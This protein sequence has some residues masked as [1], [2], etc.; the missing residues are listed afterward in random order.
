MA[1]SPSFLL[2]LVGPGTVVDEDFPAEDQGHGGADVRRGDE[3]DARF[4]DAESE[5][6]SGRDGFGGTVD[7]QQLGFDRADVGKIGRR[8]CRDRRE[9]SERNKNIRQSHDQADERLGTTARIGIN[10]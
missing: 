8:Q 6:E 3:T 7:L 5:V 4:D 9:V 10:S 1:L 2:R